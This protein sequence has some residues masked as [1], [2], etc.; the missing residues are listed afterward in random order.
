MVVPRGWRFEN[1]RNEDL[2]IVFVRGGKG[3]YVIQ[4]RRVE[5]HQLDPDGFGR[6]LCSS[7]LNQIL[8]ETWRDLRERRGGRRFDHRLEID[9]MKRY[10]GGTLEEVP[11]RY[12]AASPVTYID[13]TDSPA[14]IIFGAQDPFVGMGQVR[15]TEEK[16][17][18]SYVD[19]T[20]LIIAKGHHSYLELA[21]PAEHFPMWDYF[22][23][24]LKPAVPVSSM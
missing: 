1:R 3:H 12:R 11:D 6:S 2:H 13:R 5:N 18:S 7:I 15:T 20:I 10:L 4:D 9:S 19:H 22:D 16:A 21:S 23:T 8:I 24:H 14:L 17:R